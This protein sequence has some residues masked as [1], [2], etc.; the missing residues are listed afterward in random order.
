MKRLK[1][2]LETLVAIGLMIL[3]TGPA[4]AAQ[5]AWVECG[6]NHE[7]G[8]WED[9]LCLKGKTGGGWETMEVSETEEV[10]SSYKGLELDDTKATGGPSLVR[11]D[12]TDVGWIG[13]EG[14]DGVRSA[15]PTNCVRVTGAC[16]TSVRVTWI[17][18]PWSTRLE[19]R[20]GGEVRDAIQGSGGKEPGYL[21]E[22][23]VGGVF[24]IEDECVGAVTAGLFNDKANGTV[25]P[26][27][28]GKSG[29]QKCKLGGAES[30]ELKGTGIIKPRNG[31]AIKVRR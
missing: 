30:G 2:G 12:V 13:R 19:E 27:F 10:T 8:Q 16:E 22:C 5:P 24:K 6:E 15:A 20:S 14:G 18:L 7:H 21:V 31:R 9:S 3:M 11:C 26:E 4:M 25:E 28:E 1:I 23:T 29:K 17:N